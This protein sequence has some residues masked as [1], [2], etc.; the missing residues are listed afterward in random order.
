MEFQSPVYTTDVVLGGYLIFV[1]IDVARWHNFIS[2][3]SIL[4][5]VHAVTCKSLVN[6]HEAK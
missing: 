5:A 6:K 2:R 3:Y 4:H 1:P